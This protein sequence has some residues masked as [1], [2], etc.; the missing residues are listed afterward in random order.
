MNRLKPIHS[1]CLRHIHRVT[2]VT[3]CR[4]LQQWTRS[5][6]R[7]RSNIIPLSH[8]LWGS[9]CYGGQFWPM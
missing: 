6:W 3:R 9:V 1:F 7:Q 2:C 8:G 4:L 5:A